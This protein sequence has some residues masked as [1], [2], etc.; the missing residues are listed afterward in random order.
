MNLQEAVQRLKANADAKP[1]DPLQASSPPGPDH[2]ITFE[3]QG[4]KL[5][6]TLTRTIV[7]RRHFYQLSMGCF[8]V[9]IHNVPEVIIQNIKQ[10]FLPEGQPLPS[11][12]GNTRQFI[13][14]A[15]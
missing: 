14:P 13:F 10:I 7:M 11:V 9:P 4:F 5:K 3:E 15:S 2:W 8:N 6:V 12:L 1:F